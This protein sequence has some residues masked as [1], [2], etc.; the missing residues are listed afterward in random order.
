MILAF[1]AA[2]LGDDQT[3]I[4]NAP[5]TQISD[6]GKFPGLDNVQVAERNHGL[7]RHSPD[8]IVVEGDGLG[9]GV[10]D[11]LQH[12]YSRSLFEFHGGERPHDFY[13]CFNR[14]ARSGEGTHARLG[15]AT[16]TARSLTIV[17]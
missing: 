15:C 14:A 3:V 9:A 11:Q 10:V 5:G 6:L 17:N 1:D 2:R 16:E 4:G 7:P 13:M 12:R 8:A